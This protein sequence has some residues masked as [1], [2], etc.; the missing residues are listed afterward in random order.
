MAVIDRI[1]RALGVQVGVADIDCCH[2]LGKSKNPAEPR[3]IIVKFVSRLKKQEVLRARRVKRDFCV[4]SVYPDWANVVEARKPIYVNE[5]LTSENRAL[6]NKCRDYKRV[7]EVKFLL[8][9]D[10]RILMRKSEGS[11]VF[12]IESA[13]NL[14]DVH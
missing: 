3:G 14:K 5:H 10:G 4:Q 12:V 11:R 6:L 13:A 8:V 7:N 1:S 9:G 2:R